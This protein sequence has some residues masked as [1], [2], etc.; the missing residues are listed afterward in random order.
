MPAIGSNMLQW[1]SGLRRRSRKPQ[2][3]KVRGFKSLLQRQM[4][5]AIPAH[6]FIAQLAE[7][8]TLNL[9]VVGSI[10]TERTISRC[11]EIGQ[12]QGT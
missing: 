12:T 9:K 8:Q 10:P 3:Q 7:Q 6:A 5:E 2:A 4:P 11:G 1:P